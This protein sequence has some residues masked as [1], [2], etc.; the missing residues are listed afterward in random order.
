MNHPSKP[1][2]IMRLPLLLLAGLPWTLAAQNIAINA[3]GAAPA[4]QAMLDVS[5][6]TKGMLAPRMSAAQRA[7][8]A[9]PAQ[10]L[11]VYQTDAP[12]GFWYYQAGWVYVGSG[13]GISWDLTGNTMPTSADPNINFLG[14]TNAQPLIFRT[15]NVERMRILGTNGYLGVGTTTP[16][17]RLDVNGGLRIYNDLTTT[18]N[19]TG[20]YS[21]AGSASSTFVH[22]LTSQAGTIMYQHYPYRVDSVSSA[23]WRGDTVMWA[24][25]WGNVSSTAASAL[26]GSAT[27]PPN[28]GGWQR[29][30]NDYNEVVRATADPWTHPPGTI[31][32]TPGDLYIPVGGPAA[33]GV[34]ASSN[35]LQI[36]FGVSNNNTTFRSQYLFK[37]SELN[38]EASSAEF[39]INNPN[40]LCPGEPISAIS[41]YFYSSPAKNLPTFSVS[42]KNVPTS[43]N[44]LNTFLPTIDPSGGCY[45]SNPAYPLPLISTPG[46]YDFPL[47]TNFTWD[48]VSNV[49]VEIAGRLTGVG[50][51]SMAIYTPGWT[52]NKSYSIYKPGCVLSG[53]AANCGGALN[54][55]I[56]MNILSCAPYNAPTAGVGASPTRPIMRFRGQVATQDPA[57]ITAGTGG[58]YLQY[59]GGFM[60]ETVTGTLPWGRKMTTPFNFKGPGTLVA[61]RGVYDSGT[62]LNDHVF[63]RAFDGRV[64]PDDAADLGDQRNLT[65]EEMAAHT[66]TDRHLPTMKGRAE[67]EAEGGFSLGDLTNQLWTTTETHALYLT[68]LHD[69]L[70]TLE[71]LTNDRPL[72]G[73]E[74]VRART[75]LL[76]M[77][78]LTDGEKALLVRSLTERTTS[79]NTTR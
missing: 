49:V 45:Y 63:D 17:E 8:I 38:L 79:V 15:N 14:S 40:G 34:S 9:T 54:L 13:G 78:T 48:G 25:H 71:A 72:N 23:I 55:P 20:T 22:S 70:N 11:T 53:N 2:R 21:V 57:I 68:D 19:G 58:R 7:A 51:S 60:V 77:R 42:I 35:P 61:Q 4:A 33:A 41:L 52:G 10:G 39:G 16:T 32:A 47:T 12:K 64:H 74:A 69:R 56:T 6:T 46:W 43:F 37:A 24:G 18:G 67:W 75:D 31:C 5:S 65:M 27:A 30:G 3:T 36:P 66:R 1:L 62:R 26:P 59:P 29:L 28:P 76:R 44:S 50:A 73:T